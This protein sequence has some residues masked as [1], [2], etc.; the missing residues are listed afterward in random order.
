M[1]RK[2]KKFFIIN[3]LL[4]ITLIFTIIGISY[5]HLSSNLSIK[6][7]VK[8]INFDDE[9]TL[10][11]DSDSN[12]KLYGVITN[13]K[14][15]NDLYISE[16]IF[17][18]INIGKDTID[19]FTL[20]I[21][22]ERNI[23]AITLNELPYN[24][25]GNTVDIKNN[26]H[27][28]FPNESLDINFTVSS[29]FINN[30]ISSIKLNSEENATEISSDDFLVEFIISNYSNNIYEYDVKITNKSGKRI[31]YWRLYI[32]LPEEI[33]YLSGWDATFDRREN[34]L[35]VNSNIHNSILNNNSST[36]FGLQL[37]SNIINYIPDDIRAMVR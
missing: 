21:S 24:L 5:S 9:F 13:T 6:G 2:K 37:Y 3:I 8:G 7:N 19:N 1:K 11:P 33:T 12:L 20:S 28:L 14:K 25:R 36:T 17:K 10:T 22:F 26:K 23:R 4:F 31:T 34:I 35:I 27:S 32:T 16:Y 18:V 30:N 29:R 15:E